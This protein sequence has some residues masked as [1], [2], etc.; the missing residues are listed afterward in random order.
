MNHLIVGLGNP[1]RKYRRTRHN[2]GFLVIDSLLD[3]L[4]SAPVNSQLPAEIWKAETE[5]G[6]AY[7]MKPQT[8]MN[9]SGSAIAPFMRTKGIAPERL[10]V[11][12]DDIDLPFGKIRVRNGSSAG[13]HNVV[14]SIIE[15][16]ATK[17]FTRVRVGVGRP[18][19]GV[20]VE[21]YVLGLWNPQEDEK[22]LSIIEAARLKTEKI[23][24]T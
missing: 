8:F 20:A 13:G 16:L 24:S 14:Q 19:Q 12:H 15:A 7:F 5:G 18:P 23:L 17:D 2:L 21:E 9:L 10:V 11:I 3:N 1:G 6:A 4:D 22:L